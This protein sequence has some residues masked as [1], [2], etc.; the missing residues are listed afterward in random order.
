MWP[1]IIF[2]I[3][4]IGK[5][6]YDQHWYVDIYIDTNNHKMQVGIEKE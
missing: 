4:K 6:L 3:R 2:I 5:H 1:N